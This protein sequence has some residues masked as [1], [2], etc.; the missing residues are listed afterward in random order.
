MVEERGSTSEEDEDDDYYDSGI[1]QQ[2]TRQL[3]EDKA[4]MQ[5]QR[6]GRR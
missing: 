2:T 3:C 1:T 6:C 5:G 4:M